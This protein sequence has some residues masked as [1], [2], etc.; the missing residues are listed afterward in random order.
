MVV[1]FFQYSKRIASSRAPQAVLIEKI[2]EEPVIVTREEDDVDFIGP[3]DRLSNLRPVIRKI[4]KNETS[5]QQKFRETS[6]A[7]QKWNHDFWA[8]HNTNFAKVNYA[9]LKQNI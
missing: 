1:L 7:T 3:P 8:K 5:L 6:D 4:M 9:S 2:F